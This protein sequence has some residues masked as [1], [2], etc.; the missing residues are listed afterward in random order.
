MWATAVLVTAVVR[1]VVVLTDKGDG[2]G[3]KGDR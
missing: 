2:K 1:P 3:D